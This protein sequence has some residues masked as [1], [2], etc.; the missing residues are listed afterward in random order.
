MILGDWQHIN[1]RFSMGIVCCAVGSLN[2]YF[3]AVFIGSMVT[4]WRLS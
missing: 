1:Y 3:A 4:G 2:S